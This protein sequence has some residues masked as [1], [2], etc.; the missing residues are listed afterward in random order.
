[1]KIIEQTNDRL[2]LK[3]GSTALTLDKNE[4]KAVMRR[5]LLFFKMAPVEVPLHDITKAVVDKAADRASGIEMCSTVL[6]TRDGKGIAMPAA[7]AG[8][9]E[10]NARTV[11]E[12][13]GLKQ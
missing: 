11:R 12:F 10:A 5:K 3:A 1:M 7:D 13:L 8:E 2:A 9:A 4:D 6:V